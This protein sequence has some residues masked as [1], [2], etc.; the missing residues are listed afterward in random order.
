MYDYLNESQNH[1]SVIGSFTMDRNQDFK[2]GVKQLVEGFRSGARID[3][4]DEL[5]KILKADTLKEQ[6]K[7]QLLGDVLNEQFDDPFYD[8]LPQK[9]EQLFENSTMEVIRESGIGQMNPIVGLTPPILKKNFLECHSKDIVNTEVPSKP[10]I[11]V[12]FE[13][14]FLKDK[15]GKKYYIPEIFYDGSY[16]EVAGKAKGKSIDS[17]WYVGEGATED[18]RAAVTKESAPVRIQDL[19]IL[20]KSGGSLSTRDSL[21]YD[22]CIQAV[23]IVVGEEVKVIDGLDIQ[24]DMGAG[25]SFSYRVKTSNTSGDKTVE[26]MILGQV[27][28][29]HGTVSVTCTGGKIV[30]VKFG[31]HLSNENN[32]ETIELDRERE[33]RDWKI[34]E[35]HRINTGLTIEKIKDFKALMDI[36]V[37]AEV[38]ADMS[39]VLTQF[40]DSDILSYLDESLAMWKGKKELP[41]G[42]TEG[43]VETAKFSC[44]PPAGSTSTPSAWIDSELKFTVNRLIDELK[45]KL[46]TNEIMFVVYGH[47]NNISL[48]QE[49]VR[50]IVDEGTKI[51]GVQLDYR[52]GVMTQNHTRIHVISSLKVN[53]D[54]GLRVVAYPTS[55]ETITFKHYKYSLNI[56]NIYRNPLTPLTPNVMGTSRYL[57]T[58]V[59]PVQGELKLSDNSFGIQ[60]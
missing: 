54:A 33:R 15:E 48:L 53:K 42:Y 11:K 18:S 39:T 29:Y 32:L 38:I 9:M 36:D 25:N 45:V 50:W 59:L 23:K 13:R 20:E 52:F 28:Q 30:A 1:A 26:D 35:G 19:N 60:R 40:E 24:P 47:P 58:S 49:D 21:G 31:G 17:A 56:E 10:I 46:K 37:T 22:F 27:D 55:K 14:K 44:N 4:I 12:D 5:T 3:P 34:P 43:F 6:Y 8:L 7:E 41:F 16:K 2:D 57:T 51:G